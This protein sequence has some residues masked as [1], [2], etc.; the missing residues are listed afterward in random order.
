MN[1]NIHVMNFQI[2]GF[3][4]TFIYSCVNPLALYM[5]SDEFRRYFDHYL[6]G[7]CC[8][9]RRLRLQRRDGPS[10]MFTLDTYR[11]GA[12]RASRGSIGSSVTP[13]YSVENLN[14]MAHRRVSE[15]KQRISVESLN[16]VTLK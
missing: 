10:T 7:R 5:F 3:C 11:G 8:P 1:M 9:S 15:T 2:V 14:Y 16:T 4:L 6:F 12:T 13:N